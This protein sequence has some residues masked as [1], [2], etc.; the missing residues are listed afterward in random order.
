MVGEDVEERLRKRLKRGQMHTIEALMTALLIISVVTF[1]AR[2]VPTTST[3]LSETIAVQ[4]KLYAE[5]FLNILDMEREDHTSWLYHQ[6][7]GTVNGSFNGADE[8]MGQWLKTNLSNKGVF[9]KVEILRLNATTLT[10]ER[11]PNGTN[12]T[13]GE[14]PANAVSVWKLVT[15]LDGVV[16]EV[17]EVRLTAWQI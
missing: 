14:P 15:V 16:P 1:A 8:I 17:Y 3:Q 9:C 12:D 7:N 6:V 11:V 10:F 4:L 13:F 5:D 2:S